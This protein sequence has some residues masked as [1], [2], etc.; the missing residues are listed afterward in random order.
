M[1]AIETVIH[2]RR[3]AP[4]RMRAMVPAHVWAL[5]APYGLRPEPGEQAAADSRR[6]PP[7]PG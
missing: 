2:L 4:R 5:V 1:K 3:E 7:A 6:D